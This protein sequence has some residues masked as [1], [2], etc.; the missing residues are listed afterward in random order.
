MTWAAATQLFVN[1][2]EVT[3]AHVLWAGVCAIVCFHRR[4]NSS[5]K[6]KKSDS[7]S[8]SAFSV[9]FRRCVLP[10]LTVL[11]RAL[12]VSL[13][14]ASSVIPRKPNE[15]PSECGWEIREDAR[16]TPLTEGRTDYGSGPRNRNI[17]ST[18]HPDKFILRT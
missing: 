18:Q 11:A 3:S 7:L 16:N 10:Q 5:R 13:W 6:P 9:V 12:P 17:S 15:L 2:S 8:S 14:I 4:Q 1:A